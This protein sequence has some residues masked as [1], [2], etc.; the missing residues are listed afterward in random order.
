MAKW[1]PWTICS[2]NF[3]S[4]LWKTEDRHLLV[5]FGTDQSDTK[6]VINPLTR[7]MSVL[8]L[9]AITPRAYMSVTDY[10]VS[11]I[12]YRLYVKTEK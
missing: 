11:A 4:W 3:V 10:A 7:V 12:A 6:E 8:L 5:E 2:K 1:G 9:K